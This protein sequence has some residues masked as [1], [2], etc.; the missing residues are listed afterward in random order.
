MTSFAQ[1][2]EGD[3][4]NTTTRANME[5]WRLRN[6]Y[7]RKLNGDAR[8][9]GAERTSKRTRKDETTY[10]ARSSKSYLEDRDEKKEN[11]LWEMGEQCRMKRW[12][13]VNTRTSG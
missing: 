5:K 13:D 6:G 9:E 4:V 8:L 2:K 3:L 12:M 11:K 1:S 10:W 7:P